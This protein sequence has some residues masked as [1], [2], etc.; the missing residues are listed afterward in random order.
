MKFLIKGNACFFRLN[1][2]SVLKTKNK[3]MKKVIFVI[4]LFF[5]I[6]A[7]F[8]SH[9]VP[10]IS[11]KK[12]IH[13][14]VNF[15]KKQKKKSFIQRIILKKIQRKIDRQARK[16]NNYK[17][18]DQ[19]TKA[20]NSLIFGIGA[21]LSTII[22]F[23][24]FASATTVGATLSGLLTFGL[25]VAL[26]SAGALISG[27]NYFEGKN[28]SDEKNKNDLKAKFGTLIGSIILGIILILLAFFK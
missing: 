28:Q 13:Q 7:P 25:L 3:N 10:V 9:A 11:Q 26:C 15:S 6:G 21:L 14:P 22:G 23:F 17:K 27:L 20:N 24:V 5:I 8:Y 12:S 18:I 16:R 2:S 4:T 1:S 19:R